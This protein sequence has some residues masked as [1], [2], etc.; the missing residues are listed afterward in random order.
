MPTNDDR[1][2]RVLVV[3]DSPVV[4]RR[5]CRLLA[6]ERQ[7]RVIAEADTAVGAVIQFEAHR[8]DAVLLDI[9]LPD[10]SGVELLRWFKRSSPD[11]TVVVLTNARIP[12]LREACTRDGADFF[13]YKASEFEAAIAALSGLATGKLPHR[14]PGPEAGVRSPPEHHEDS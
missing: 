8:P 1:L 3:D 11:C 12:D 6:E 10:F 2:I 4:R 14:K 5:L 9:H 13:F 7:V